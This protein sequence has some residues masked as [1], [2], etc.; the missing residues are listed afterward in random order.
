M[1]IKQSLA[2][3][4]AASSS[5]ER[6]RDKKTRRTFELN[7]KQTEE[8]SDLEFEFIETST[9]AP[10][11]VTVQTHTNKTIFN[12][13]GALHIDRFLKKTKQVYGIHKSF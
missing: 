10:P 4:K 1:N 6:E 11:A 8:G 9:D 13:K 2:S 3:T 5:K 7:F 12:Y